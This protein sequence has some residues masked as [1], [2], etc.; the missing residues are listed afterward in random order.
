MIFIRD[1]HASMLAVVRTAAMVHLHPFVVDKGTP[2]PRTLE[3]KTRLLAPVR[4]LQG[5]CDDVVPA[6]ASA[7]TMCAC[8]IN[9]AF[10][11]T[12]SLLP[13][14]LHARPYRPPRHRQELRSLGT[15]KE[16]LSSAPHEGNSKESLAA[17]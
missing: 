11:I 8:G 14:H 12:V 4:R 13:I 17:Y 2:E 1:L 6:V 3:P 7:L 16:A 9:P 15:E 10:P 5:G